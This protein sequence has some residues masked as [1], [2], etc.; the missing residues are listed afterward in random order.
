[1][2]PTYRSRPIKRVRRTQAEIAALRDRLFDIVEANKPATVRQVFYLAVTQLELAKTEATYKN[3][4]C[5]LLGIMRREKQLPYDWIA[6]NTRWQRKPRTYG[7]L[8]DALYATAEWYRRDLWADADSYVE[9]WTEKDAI[10]G[11]IYQVTGKWDVPLMV[12]RGF[13]SISFLHS[14]AEAI[15][16]KSKPT[17]LYYFG[18]HDPSGVH[19]DRSIERELVALA[20]DAEIHFKRIAVTLEQIEELS[21]PTRPTKK[22][23]SR[24]RSFTGESVEVDAIPPRTLQRMVEDCIIRHVDHERLERLKLVERAERET[25]QRFANVDSDRLQE[26]A[27]ALEG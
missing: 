12:S 16:A 15:A 5:R 22:T 11:V 25:L 7:S 27:E 24:S 18:D 10:A 20:P 19:I 21:L 26:I 17:F 23:D 6:D 3:V 8:E 9:I 2:A 14:A 4:V 1:M 13:S